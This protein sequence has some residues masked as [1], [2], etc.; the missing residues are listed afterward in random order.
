M[1][2]ESVAAVGAALDRLAIGLLVFDGR[3]RVAGANPSAER[4]L[5]AR[6]GSLAG[7]TAMETFLDHTVEQLLA[8]A[9]AGGRSTAEL[10]RGGEP[11]RVLR[12][13]AWTDAAGT[14]VT[15]EDHSELRRLQRI[16]TEFIG[17]LSHELRTPLT[18]VRLLAESLTLEAE[19]APLPQRVND[20]IARI[21]VE[22]GHLAQMV[23]E[24]L[25]LSTIEH[26][27]AP[28]RRENLD[29][30]ALVEASL[31]RL[32]TYAERQ[33]VALRSEPATAGEMTVAGD[34]ERL[35][36]VATNIVHNAI[37]FSSPGDEVVARVS[38]KDEQ[39]VLEV[40]DH[41]PG[42]PRAERGRIFERFYKVD[43]ARSRGRGGT[44][45][46]LAIARHIVE[47]HGGRI[48]VESEEGRGARF[49]VSLPRAARA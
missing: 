13:N 22:T 24:L 27:D 43:R 4:L 47:R 21:D 38:A 45:L 44:G 29:L 5:D 15:L 32:R 2:A 17:N 19:R 40:E 3:G 23:S 37:K 48:W 8:G 1:S 28:L 30:G 36:Q 14:W 20:A 33:G 42:I 16:R 35:A 12:L 25:D 6:S 39:V 18:T 46:G 34:A 31:E 7:K 10:T 41:G 11:A 26:G 49:F 9:R